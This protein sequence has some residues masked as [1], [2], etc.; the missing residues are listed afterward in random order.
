MTHIIAIVG[1]V[2]L[3]ALV[4]GMSATVDVSAM[5]VQLRNVKAL[6]VGMI[7]QFFIT[8]LLGFIVVRT[9]QLPMA[10]GITL[11]VVTSSPGG[12]YSNWWCSL[13]N[14]D[15]ALSIT[16]TA[17]ST[18]LSIAF[19]PLNL[20]IYTKLCYD[21][22]VL[23][24]VDWKSLFVSLAIVISA[25]AT[26]LFCSYSTHSRKFN[27]IANCLGNISGLALIIM[28]ATM[29]NTGGEAGDDTKIWNHHWTFYVGTLL[30][31][32]GALLISTCLAYLVGLLKPECV[33]VAIEACYQNVGIATSLALTMFEG[34]EI[35]EAMGIPFLYGV[36]E[37]VLVGIYCLI[38][39]K[40]NWTKAPADAPIWQVMLLSYEVIEAAAKD[41]IDEIEVHM[42]ES[43]DD[44]KSIERHD[45]NILTTYFTWLDPS[46]PQP[47]QPHSNKPD[48]EQQM[49]Y[50]SPTPERGD[51]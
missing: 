29:A 28:S 44:V 10:Q 7:C 43:G 18:I 13:F 15:L 4:F 27:H 9:L 50:V 51:V 11:L 49:S 37:G 5:F 20:L 16:M 12:S 14:A 41:D 1:N 38:T 48:K 22:D 31:C 6:S 21:A 23:D 35:R 8:P 45:G 3:F 24:K 46:I 34:E 39:W 47:Q 25:I 2:L 17:M 33:T 19:L 26:G 40:A 32:L 36:L 30:P 42:S